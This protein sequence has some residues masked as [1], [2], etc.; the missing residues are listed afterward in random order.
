MNKKM[1]MLKNRWPHYFLC[2]I[3]FLCKKI[4]MIFSAFIIFGIMFK[5]RKILGGNYNVNPMIF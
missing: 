4:S 1:I 3:R 2:P 5:I